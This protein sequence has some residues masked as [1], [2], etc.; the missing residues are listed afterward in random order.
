MIPE[1]HEKFMNA[2]REALKKKMFQN[3][4]FYKLTFAEMVNR[5]E[6]ILAT[7]KGATTK[8]D[9][10]RT[11]CEKLGIRPTSLS[12]SLWVTGRQ[13]KRKLRAIK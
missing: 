11:T 13:Y 3:E 12:A 9:S 5:M 10:F 4:E 8:N 7:G 1:R 6:C 2:Y